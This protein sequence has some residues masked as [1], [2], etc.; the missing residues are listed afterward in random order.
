MSEQPSI[1]QQLAD[2]IYD[3]LLLHDI[4]FAKTRSK[5]IADAIVAA[6]N[7]GRCPPIVPDAPEDGYRERELTEDFYRCPNTGHW[8]YKWRD[9]RLALREDSDG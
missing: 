9:E 4:E 2:V 3:D 1:E 7:E 5:R 8:V 6:V